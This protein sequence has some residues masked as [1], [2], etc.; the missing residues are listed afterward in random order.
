[1]R[2][3]PAKVR[4]KSILRLKR[5]AKIESV[6]G[7]VHPQVVVHAGKSRKGVAPREAVVHREHGA[8]VVEAAFLGVVGEPEQLGGERILEAA[9]HRL[10]GHL[11]AVAPIQLGVDT[12]LARALIVE[13]A[14]GLA[15]HLEL[16]AAPLL[17]IGDLH[18]QTATVLVITTV[19]VATDVVGREPDVHPIVQAVVV[20]PHR[21]EPSVELREVVVEAQLL[22]SRQAPR[23]T[24]A[25]LSLGRDDAAE[26][27]RPFALRVGTCR[28]E[29]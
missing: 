9:V 24:Q 16:E 5:Q 23:S 26:V 20:H 7:L 12:M 10:V 1:M 19:V 28:Q 8:Q 15:A 4:I 6:Y 27:G 29:Q 22:F 13:G 18:A 25:H 2:F 3:I 21:V 17:G 14:D 11:Q